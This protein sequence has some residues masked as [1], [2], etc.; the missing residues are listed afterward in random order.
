MKTKVIILMIIIILF[1]VFVSQNTNII[2]VNVLL[3]KFE[4]STIVLISITFL[5]GLIIGFILVSMF[6]VPKKKEKPENIIPKEEKTGEN[7]KL[8]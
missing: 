7:D 4:M 6:S 5:V 3:W 2:P 8:V 1:T